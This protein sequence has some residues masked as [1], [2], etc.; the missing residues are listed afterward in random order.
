ML[1]DVIFNRRVTLSSLL[2]MDLEM[3]PRLAAQMIA[4]HRTRLSEQIYRLDHHTWATPK[5]R[6]DWQLRHIMIVRETERLL[7]LDN[8]YVV[9]IWTTINGEDKRG[10]ELGHRKLSFSKSP[11]SRRKIVFHYISNYASTN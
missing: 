1:I 8:I 4:H 6:L 9:L 10:R 7:L 5:D 3:T 2:G 11:E